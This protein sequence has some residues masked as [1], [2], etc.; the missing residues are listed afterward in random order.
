MK[1][2]P[3]MIPKPTAENA[4]ATS[5]PNHAAARCEQAVPAMP[6]LQAKFPT[7][8]PRWNEAARMA[9][10]VRLP[11]PPNV[12][13]I[14]PTE[15]NR[16]PNKE[17]FDW[18][19]P[20]HRLEFRRDVVVLVRANERVAIFKEMFDQLCAN[21][22]YSAEGMQFIEEGVR[23]GFSRCGHHP[24]SARISWSGRRFRIGIRP[25]VY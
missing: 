5:A 14:E 11:F 25:R 22:N 4:M 7:S 19:A 8:L 17:K 2:S 6:R 3:A 24:R 18:D 10:G 12:E 13:A 9:E 1:S 20:G 23:P 15:K 21:R 16:S